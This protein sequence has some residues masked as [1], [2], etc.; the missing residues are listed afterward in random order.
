LHFQGN[1]VSVTIDDEVVITAPVATGSSLTSRAQ[2]G[3]LSIH[4]GSTVHVAEI[5]VT[6]VGVCSPYDLNCDGVVDSA[7]VLL[8]LS[9]WGSDSC[10]ADINKD[11]VVN[12]SDLLLLLNNWG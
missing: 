7:D 2:I 1:T 5:L 3:D 12:S 6:G 4:A 10:I 9:A 11:G 8:L